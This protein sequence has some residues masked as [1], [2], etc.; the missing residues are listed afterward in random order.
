MTENGE[1][2]LKKILQDMYYWQ[3]KLPT[4]LLMLFQQY[5]KRQ[6]HTTIMFPQSQ[7]SLQKIAK[8]PSRPCYIGT[9]KDLEN[10]QIRNGEGKIVLNTYE[11]S[12]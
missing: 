9:E 5:A 1:L 2:N 12:E 10:Y 7:L 3:I 8:L 11:F 4:G 6:R